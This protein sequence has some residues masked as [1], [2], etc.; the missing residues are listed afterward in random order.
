MLQAPSSSAGQSY[1]TRYP[2]AFGPSR[3]GIGL[4][5]FGVTL[6]IVILLAMMWKLNF[7]EVEFWSGL[8]DLGKM[9]ALMIPPTPGEHLGGIIDGMLETLAI[10]FLGTLIASINAFFIGFLAAR[11]IVRFPPLYFGVRRFLDAIRSVD[12]II[13]ALI[14][15][16]GLGLGPFAGILAIAIYD[17]GTLSKLYGE[18]IENVDEKP[19]EGI[20]ATGG[21]WFD[22]L[23]YG[24][25]P[26]VLPVMVSNSLYFLESNTRSS[27]IVGFVGAGGI[28]LIL[29]DRAR[30]FNWDEVAFIII[31]IIAAV[32][33]IDAISRMIRKRVIGYGVEEPAKRDTLMQKIWPSKRATLKK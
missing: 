21:G 5:V 20:R 14:F 17:T 1:R 27:T 2:Q 29:F 28:G 11:N 19:I 31:T 13:W 3:L 33:I 9:I 15:V 8:G 25:T 10:A 7:H 6:A 30:T 22:L 4:R 26:Q 18:A 16:N 12:A 24:Y 23:R 32:Y